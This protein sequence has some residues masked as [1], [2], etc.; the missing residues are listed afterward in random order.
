MLFRKEGLFSSAVLLCLFQEFREEKSHNGIV[1]EENRCCSRRM[2]C[3]SVQRNTK[4]FVCLFQEKK[5]LFQEQA[6]LLVSRT[7]LLFFCCFASLLSK[8]QKFLFF[9]FGQKKRKEKKRKEKK[10]KEKKRKE[11]KRET[12]IKTFV[13]LFQEGFVSR[14]RRKQS[15]RIQRNG[16]FFSCSAVL[17]FKEKKWCCSAACFKNSKKRC[18]SVQRHFLFKK[19]IT[20]CFKKKKKHKV[21]S[22]K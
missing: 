22:N 5:G 1:S 6:G 9:C 21:T 20:F 16:A 3:S 2:F 10:R 8:N 17:L 18:S 14:T 19:L 12:R 4:V 15:W 11:E 7:A 13:Y